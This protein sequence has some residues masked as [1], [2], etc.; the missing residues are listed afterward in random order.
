M[1][2]TAKRGTTPKNIAS[3]GCTPRRGG[4]INAYEAA[5]ADLLVA[6]R[7]SIRSRSTS[8]YLSAESRSLSCWSQRRDSS[9][10]SVFGPESFAARCSLRL[11][12]ARRHLP[13]R[14][15]PAPITIVPSFVPF[16]FKFASQF[17]SGRHKI[18]SPPVFE[19]RRNSEVS[20]APHSKT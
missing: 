9:G 17:G 13:R 10:S 2:K 1:R 5:G 16:A 19:Q 12:F 14:R 3:A 8:Q 4:D 11:D 6:K 7:S 18:F 20:R 15:L